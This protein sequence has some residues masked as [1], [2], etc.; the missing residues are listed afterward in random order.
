MAIQA[1]ITS[2]DALEAFRADL[3]V[4]LG[5]ARRSVD[6]TG[7]E[8]RRTRQWLQHEQ[9]AHWEAELH[10]RVR[11]VEQLTAE[12]RSAQF[13]G[14]RETAVMVRQAAVNKAKQKVA[15]AENK[16]RI[17]KKW[18]QNYD[19]VSDPIV[20]RLESL[21]QYLDNDLPKAIAY[22][23]NVQRILEDYAQ[24]PSAGSGSAPASST[25]PADAPQDTP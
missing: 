24:T 14:G 10:R 6:D 1:R 3:I 20:R 9:R 22:L 5:K 4:F 7:D 2:T 12:L 15:E 8:V 25:P 11:T 23:G 16:L 18:S 17:I 21:R 13:M 19:H